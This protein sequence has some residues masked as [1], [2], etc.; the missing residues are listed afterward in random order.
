MDMASLLGMFGGGG[1]AAAGGMQ[2]PALQLGQASMGG[3]QP[4]MGFGLGQDMMQGQMGGMDYA[5]QSGF[6]GMN[7]MM[8]GLD[9]QK[10]GPIMQ[11]MQAQNQRGGQPQMLPPM[12]QMGGGGQRGSGG[13]R[14]YLAQGGGVAPRQII[15]KG[16]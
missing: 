5:Q 16:Y 9:M 4:G 10:L 13:T 15:N 12:M 14:D 7:D 6:G 2:M 11:M 3:Q 8:A 1:G